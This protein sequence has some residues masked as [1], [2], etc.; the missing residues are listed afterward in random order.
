MLSNARHDEI[1]HRLEDRIDD[2]IEK[3]T[4]ERNVLMNRVQ[5][6]ELLPVLPDVGPVEVKDES[7]ALE[8]SLIGQ[9]VPDHVN[10]PVNDSGEAAKVG[11][12][13]GA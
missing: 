11:T 9:V 7:D 3:A 4:V 6:P 13:E 10:L 2:L 5:R 8:L 12:I 1:V